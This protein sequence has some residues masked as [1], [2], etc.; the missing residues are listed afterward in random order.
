MPPGPA[1]RPLRS[2]F[3]RGVDGAVAAVLVVAAL[4]A[5]LLLSLAL[6]GTTSRSSAPPTTAPSTTAPAPTVPGGPSTTTTIAPPASSDPAASALSRMV[7]QQSDV[8]TADTVGLIQGGNSVTGEA[9]LDLCNGTFPSESLRTA[10]EQVAAVDA[11]GNDVLS[12]EAVAY[13]NAAATLQAFGELKSV[14]ANCPSTPVVSP[15]GEQT[16]TTRFNPSPD[17]NWPNVAGVSRLA[18][19]FVT[20]D[21]FG[22]SEHSVAVYLRRGR[23]LIGVYFPTPGNSQVAVDGKATMAGIVDVFATRL[24]QL[25]AS[26]VGS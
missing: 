10:R 9:T 22:T 21:Q 24:S 18:Y 23:I 19:D 25:P 15:V 13:K 17:G 12:T 4:G 11:Q 1:R 3:D 5:G 26:L 14:A 2:L 8:P 16:V 20:T 7:L 6:P